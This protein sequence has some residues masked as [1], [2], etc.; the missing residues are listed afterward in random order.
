[1]LFAHI[2]IALASVGLTTYVFFKPSHGVLRGAYALMGATLVTGSALMVNS[3]AH[4]VQA[5]AIG[6][7]YT[8]GVGY[9][10]FAARHKL[11]VQTIKTKK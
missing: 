1:M 8:T 4:M 3:P 6:L 5:C 2:S 9:G 7:V 11:A 10:L